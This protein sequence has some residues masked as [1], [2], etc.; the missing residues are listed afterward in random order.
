IQ[1]EP[2]GKTIAGEGN[3]VYVP[4]ARN[5]V[6]PL[7]RRL[8]PQERPVRVRTII[9]PSQE[10]SKR[11]L[12]VVDQRFQQLQTAPQARVI[13]ELNPLIIG[14]A[15]YYNGVVPAATMSRYD[16]LMEQRLINWA[17]KR[18]PGKNRDWLLGRYWQHTGERRRV[19]ATRDGQ[20]LRAYQ[21]TSILGG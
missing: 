12:A 14:W 8:A 10:A 2:V 13:E 15:A 6:P 16:D 18:H 11:H 5:I 7:A 19:F 1:Q 3:H 21:Q 9:T 4:G 17:S 20:R